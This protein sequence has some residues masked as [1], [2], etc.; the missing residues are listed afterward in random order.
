MNRTLRV[1]VCICAMYIV[2]DSLTRSIG[3]FQTEPSRS[4]I[5][6]GLREVQNLDLIIKIFPT[7][8]FYSV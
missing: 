3:V 5:W 1:S 7:V 8:V 4:A 2:S 6:D